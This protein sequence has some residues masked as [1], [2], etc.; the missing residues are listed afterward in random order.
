MVQSGGTSN[1]V[2]WSSEAFLGHRA[3]D[4]IARAPAIAAEE[5]AARGP[6]T[7]SERYLAAS[8]AAKAA[9]ADTSA[10]AAARL[11]SSCFAL[12]S[13]TRFLRS[14]SFS[15]SFAFFSA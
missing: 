8:A 2:L 1:G 9:A 15:R 13:A 10:S 5:H 11:S 4:S 12:R 3:G 6:L 7:S 14:F